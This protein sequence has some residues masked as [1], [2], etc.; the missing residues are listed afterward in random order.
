MKS[1]ATYIAAVFFFLSPVSL[2]AQSVGQVECPRGGGY[3]YLYSSMITLDVRTTLQ[4]GEQVQITGRYDVYFGVR[5][6]KGELGYVPV[7][8]LL[9]LKDKPGTKTPQSAP[10][11]PSRERITYDAPTAKPQAPKPLS[12]SDLTLLNGTPIRVMLGKTLSSASSHIGDV[13][14]LKVLEE[15]D[16]DGLCVIPAGATA[17]GIVKEAEPKKRMGRGGKLGLSINFVRLSNGEKAAVRSYL[18]SSGTNSSTGAVLPL[19]TGKDVVI[20]QGTEFTAFVDGDLHLKKEA[21]QPAKDGSMP[22]PTP[23]AQNPSHPL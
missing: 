1:S 17:I 22:A 12:P 4:C 13:V 14:E 18:E 11:Q 7:D 8:S 9:L 10:A 3:V 21:F 23:Q 6:T 5:T 2:R 15:V 16:V 19:A 20:T